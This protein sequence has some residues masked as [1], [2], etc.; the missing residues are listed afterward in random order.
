MKIAGVSMTY[1]DGYKLKEWKEHYEGYKDE[2]DYY[3]I[4]DN[5]SEKYYLN[6]LEKVFK[7]VVVIK[8]KINGGCT[9]AY[10]DGIRYILNNT[11]AD[12]IVIIANDFKIKKGCLHKMYEYLNS[13]ELLGL[14]STAILEKDS[15]K[16]AN[17]GHRI[18]RY[19][20]IGLDRGKDIQE[21]KPDRK[22]TDLVAGGFYMAKRKFYKDVGLQDEKLFMYGDEYDT[23]IRAKRAGYKVGVTCETYGWHWH[24]N[25]PNASGRRPAS[26]YLI[27]RNR[28]YVVRKH[29]GKEM[30]LGSFWHFSL[31]LASKFAISGLLKKNKE[32]LE[33][34]KFCLMG[35]INGLKGDMSINKYTKF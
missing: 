35:G 13:D 5:G 19:K 20:V 24:I 16:V 4:V 15:T 30:V 31:R 14:V 26:N 7:D 10:N 23:A 28:I 3:V 8:R 6:E 11:D 33:R 25:E 21:I 22:Y 1:N 32:S 29:F 12:A 18:D 2:L 9:A 27:A 17:Y 34:A